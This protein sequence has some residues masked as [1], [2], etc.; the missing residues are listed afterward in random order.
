M[1]LFDR[2]VNR[3]LGSQTDKQIKKLGL[4][5]GDLGG[6]STDHFE[7]T[8]SR[9]T[10]GGE[11]ATRWTAPRPDHNLSWE[12]AVL[13]NFLTQYRVTDR[14]DEAPAGDLGAVPPDLAELFRS[15]AGLTFNDGLYRIHTPRTA[16]DSNEFCARLI[17]GFADS[18][19]CFGFDWLGRNLAIDMSG[20]GEPLVVLVEPGAGEYMESGMG[21]RAFH[22]ETLVEDPTA[23]AAGFFDE[24][25]AA[26]PEFTRLRYDQCIGCKVP[27]FLGGE[28]E[29][30]NLEVVPYDVYWELCVQLRTGVRRM[31][32]GTSI[33]RIIKASE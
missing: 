17:Q 22:D 8:L 23:L 24:W 6:R 21:I 19:Y 20:R 1:S 30:D 4:S 28:D 27:L 10:R 13:E 11:R 2:S 29:V 15:M 33:G 18:M 14:L 32:P 26:H 25:R 16:A 12:S 7:I 3:S 9:F 31:A 5:P